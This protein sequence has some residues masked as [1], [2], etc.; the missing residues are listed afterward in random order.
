MFLPNL[1]FSY[2]SLLYTHCLCHVSTSILESVLLVGNGYNH[3]SCSCHMEKVLKE[4]TLR[5]NAVFLYGDSLFTLTTTF[6]S[7]Y[8]RFYWSCLW[9]FARNY[10]WICNPSYLSTSSGLSLVWLL[11]FSYFQDVVFVCISISGFSFNLFLAKRKNLNL[12]VKEWN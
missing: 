4:Y 10:F 9:D 2:H 3:A 12:G 7:T 11:F 5:L 6:Y 1:Y 8:C